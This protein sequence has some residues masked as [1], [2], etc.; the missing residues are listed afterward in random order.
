MKTLDLE[1]LN[2]VGKA[3]HLRLAYA[4][5]DLD[6]TTVKHAMDTIAGLKMFEKDLVNPYAT[7][8]AATYIERKV[9]PIFGGDDTEAA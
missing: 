3:K 7:P 6:E 2:E 5:Q 8:R 4:N 1:F 9:T